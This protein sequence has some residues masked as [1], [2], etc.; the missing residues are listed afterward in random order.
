MKLNAVMKLFYRQMAFVSLFILFINCAM[1]I[2]NV[3]S[4]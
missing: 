4:L 1:M 3:S 2:A